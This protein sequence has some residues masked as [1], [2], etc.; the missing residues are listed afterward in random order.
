MAKPEADTEGQGKEKKLSITLKGLTP[1]LMNNPAQT[2]G[3]GDEE[4]ATRGKVKRPTTEEDAKI[5]RYVTP[6]GNLYIPAEALRKCLLTASSGYTVKGETGRKLALRA[7]LAGAL[8]ITLPYCQLV[9]ENHNPLPGDCYEVEAR[10]VVIGKSAIIRGRPKVF[11]WYALCWYNID[12][13]RFN[14]QVFE[15]VLVRAGKYPGLLDY[16]PEKSGWFGTF[17]VVDVEYEVIK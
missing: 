4:T 8:S 6:E 13:A 2:L 5:R 3:R 9:D 12:L 14:E 1:L 16:R 15:S 10:R 11:P 17:E 7:L